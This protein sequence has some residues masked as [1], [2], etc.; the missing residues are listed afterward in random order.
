[1]DRSE[2][3]TAGNSTGSAIGQ[4]PLP[5]QACEGGT[6]LTVIKRKSHSPL[7]AAVPDLSSMLPPHC[8]GMTFP[9]RKSATSR[10]VNT[11]RGLCGHLGTAHRTTCTNWNCWSWGPQS[12]GRVSRVQ[13]NCSGTIR[14]GPLSSQAQPERAPDNTV[15]TAGGRTSG[16]IIHPPELTTPGRTRRPRPG[17]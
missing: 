10:S 14:P 6:K 11:C 4:R 15:G 16:G 12:R 7:R 13:T 9:E 5:D 2:D 8:V 3:G 17:A 1:M